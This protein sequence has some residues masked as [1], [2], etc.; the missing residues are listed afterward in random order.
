MAATPTW[1]VTPQPTAQ[2]VIYL[3]TL[4]VVG[5]AATVNEYYSIPSGLL[6]QLP[7]ATYV[8]AD[9]FITVGGG[10][11]TL[12]PVMSCAP[13]PTFASTEDGF[14]SSFA[15]LSTA[16]VVATQAVRTLS[17]RPTPN[18]VGDGTTTLTLRVVV[19][20]WLAG[21]P[22]GT[23]AISQWIP[24]TAVDQGSAPYDP[25]GLAAASTFAD[26]VF[27]FIPTPAITTTY[28]DNPRV[29]IAPRWTVNLLALWP[30][31]SFATDAVSLELEFISRTAKTGDNV[32]MGAGVLDGG[33]P[34][35]TTNEGAASILYDSTLTA[36]QF[37]L[38]NGGGT[39]GTGS[40]TQTTG[41]IFASLNPVAGAVGLANVTPTATLKGRPSG[42]DWT[43]SIQGQ[44]SDTMVD[45][46]PFLHFFG[47]RGAILVIPTTVWTWRA[48]VARTR[49]APPN[50]Q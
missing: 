43:N 19:I 31:F 5:I 13:S 8:R 44:G 28:S 32:G 17:I 37:R 36:D 24:I 39:V 1:T 11:A 48:W 7:V 40:F 10:V 4:V 6:P 2:G 20:P 29:A 9:S 50:V 21:A 42:G 38:S 23:G 15:S 45:G 33:I 3:V 18:V 47:V 22:S 34:T 25:S 35:I 41:G 26:G 30:D 27:S 16:P 49:R 12:A 14:I 46:A